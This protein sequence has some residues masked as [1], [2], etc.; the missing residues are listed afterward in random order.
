MGDAI[1]RRLSPPARCRCCGCLQTRRRC[2]RSR[3]RLEAREHPEREAVRRVS[4]PALLTRLPLPDPGEPDT[5]SPVRFLVW[6]ARQQR[7]TVIGGGFFGAVWM[8]S[9]SLIPAALGAAIDAVARRDRAELWTWSAVVLGLGIVQAVT[10]V[11]R[12]RRAVANF[13]PPRCGSSNW[14]RV[15]RAISGGT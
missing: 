8:G 2:P 3:H 9:Q 10:G 5:R 7:A 1:P 14:W 6:L 13:S 15:R 4:W 11:L 12:H